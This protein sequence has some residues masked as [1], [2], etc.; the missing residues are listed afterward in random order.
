MPGQLY[1]T[2]FEAQDFRSFDEVKLSI[3]PT[4]GVVVLE[5]PN[6]LGKTT[7]FEAI[8]LALTGMVHRWQKLSD[9]QRVDVRRHLRRAGTQES[10]PCEIGL[11]FSGS[12]G[13]SLAASWKLDDPGHHQVATWLCS[14][15]ELWALT[16]DNLAGF[17]RGTHFLPQSPHIRWLHLPDDKRWEEVLRNVSGYSEITGLSEGLR[18]TGPQLTQISNERSQRHQRA[19]EGL[20]AWRRRV[21]TATASQDAARAADDAMRP[22]SA[23]ALLH[24]ADVPEG[25]W[26]DGVEDARTL[27][28]ALATVVD[29]RRAGREEASEQRLAIASLGGMPAQWA[30]AKAKATNAN[31]ALETQRSREANA[32]LLLEEGNT[33]ESTARLRLQ[34]VEEEAE[35]LRKRDERSRLLLE[36]ERNLPGWRTAVQS[37]LERKN[38]FLLDFENA[39]R[40]DADA[41]SRLEKRRKWE[42]Q[43]EAL[44]RRSDVLRAQGE[45]WAAVQGLESRRR[46]LDVTHEE[47]VRFLEPKRLELASQEHEFQ[48]RQ[49]AVVDAEDRARLAREA[50]GE[51]QVL[52]AALAAHV[53]HQDTA[54]PLCLAEYPSRG[55]LIERIAQ[56]QAK[57]SGALA[58]AEVNLRTKREALEI[59]EKTLGAS[60]ASVQVLQDRLASLRAERDEAGHQVARLRNDLPTDSPGHE[61]E[62]L[63]RLQAVLGAETSAHASDPSTALEPVQVLEA[64]LN[65]T[66]ESAQRSREAFS[67]GSRALEEAE[68]EVR[69]LEATAAEARNALAADPGFSAELI[70]NSAAAGLAEALALRDELASALRSFTAAREAAEKTVGEAVSATARADAESTGATHDIGEIERRWT[71][72]RLA[73]PPTAEQITSRLAELDS[74]SSAL[75][76]RLAALGQASKGIE[77]WLALSSLHEELRALDVEAGGHGADSW[78][79]HEGRLEY[80]V[81][82]SD[83]AARRAATARSEIARMSDTAALKRDSMRRELDSRLEPVLAP[84]LRALIV[85]PEISKAVLQLTESHRR[86]RVGA[87]L[88][89]GATPLLARVSE[90][91]LAGV[92]LAIQLAMA[93]AFPW[94]RWR[95][96]L[97]D[98]PTQYCDVIH[99][100]NLVETLRMFARQRGFQ[101]FIS[102]HEHDFARYVERK[103]LNDGLFAKR[104][105]FREPKTPGQ[106]VVPILVGG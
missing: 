93:L 4:A 27:L 58:A 78:R 3:P 51:V 73:L 9:D 65:M 38:A 34:E 57:Q 30:E 94:S 80:E 26:T 22:L 63:Q 87:S 82:Q 20:G 18:A 97:L 61:S 50:E 25:S 17:L 69:R 35:V 106:G 45:V 56:A 89:D 79:E 60:R 59:F 36:V 40:A 16:P 62:V 77:R 99:S 5:G 7:W 14:A 85:N 47:I 49:E 44:A 31:L 11:G 8:E 41:Q 55:V 10:R 29:S 48:S 81:S 104:L 88:G 91:Q 90:G 46:E 95:A 21:A 100:A 19:Q 86:T 98:D 101:I 24:P 42:G 1:L 67:E 68:S 52:L 28:T 96:V 105:L 6:G 15:K 23:T 75:E 74:V 13:E 33:A 64:Q 71:L 53:R 37:G 84:L 103:F 83:S 66:S 12:E 32:R 43:R 2:R 76:R 92:N 54:C 70:A 72:H 102:T 39:T